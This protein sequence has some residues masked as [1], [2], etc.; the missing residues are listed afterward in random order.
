MNDLTRLRS[1]VFSRTVSGTKQLAITKVSCRGVSKLVADAE[2][3]HATILRRQAELVAAVISYQELQH[4]QS[5]ESVA[6]GATARYAGRLPR[7]STNSASAKGRTTNP[8]AQTPE[9]PAAGGCADGLTASPR[10]A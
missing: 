8:A 2:N 7:F 10:C 3:G 1:E 9:R 6:H 4:L 5:L